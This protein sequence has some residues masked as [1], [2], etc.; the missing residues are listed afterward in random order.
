MQKAFSFNHGRRLDR[1]R[2][3]ALRKAHKDKHSKA[4][5][6]KNKKEGHGTVSVRQR[7]SIS[8]SNGAYQSN[9]HKTGLT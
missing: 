9:T 8:K 3:L 1:R 2:V 5:V 7:K 4:T 6:T